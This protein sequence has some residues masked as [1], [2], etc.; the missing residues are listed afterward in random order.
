MAIFLIEGMK[1][2]FHWNGIHKWLYG[3]AGGKTKICLSQKEYMFNK[4]IIHASPFVVETAK[5]NQMKPYSHVFLS[6]FSMQNTNKISAQVTVWESW[7]FNLKTGFLPFTLSLSLSLWEKLSTFPLKESHNLPSLYIRRHSIWEVSSQ[8]M[9][10]C[11]QNISF[12]RTYLRQLNFHHFPWR[13][14]WM[15]TINRKGKFR[16]KY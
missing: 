4:K 1:W 5:V 7:S 10:R 13:W 2:K 3:R 11:H 12:Q 9:F 6:K 8:A 14:Q 15:F 16:L